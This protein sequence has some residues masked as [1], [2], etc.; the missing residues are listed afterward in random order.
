VK[1]AAGDVPVFVN[2]G[3]RAH[4]AEEQLGI[5][6]GAVIGTFFKKDGVFENAVDQARVEELMGVVKGMRKKR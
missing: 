6:D 2:T 3:V 5:A 4:N 1:G